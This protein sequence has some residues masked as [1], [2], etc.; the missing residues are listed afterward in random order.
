MYTNSLLNF[1]NDQFQ[2]L[3]S[4]GRPKPQST[5][6]AAL[7]AEAF[8]AVPPNTDGLLAFTYP[9]SALPANF[10]PGVHQNQPRRRSDLH[11]RQ[12]PDSNL[13]SQQH[14]KKARAGSGKAKSQSVDKAARRASQAVELSNKLQQRLATFLE[15]VVASPKPDTDVLS[16]K[17]VT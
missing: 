4:D 15:L 9:Q 1:A 11:K 17:Q 5:A 6:S 10:Q 8:W 7:R 3:E 16:V 12:Q 2:T 14:H 13:V